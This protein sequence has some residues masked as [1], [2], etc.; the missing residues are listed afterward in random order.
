MKSTMVW[1][2]SLC[3]VLVAAV[4]LTFASAGTAAER[5]VLNVAGGYLG[6]GGPATNASFALASGVVRDANGNFYVSDALDC[7][8]R[9]VSASGL[10]TTFAGTGICGHSGD[11]GP[12][13]EARIAN[14]YSLAFDKHGN[15]LIGDIDVVRSITPGGII[16]TI[17]GNGRQG[18]SGDGGPATKA[19]FSAIYGM[20]VDSSGNIFIVDGNNNV[21]RQI[22]TNGIVRT[23]AGN[24]T[25]GFSGDGGPATS[26]SLNFPW[27]VAVD[28]GGHVYV[29]DDNNYRVRVFSV[30]GTISTFAGNGQAG[31]TGSGGPATDAAIGPNAGLHLAAGRLYIGG[32]TGLIWAVNMS[33]KTIDQIG[34]A[35]SSGYNGD[36]KPA[37]AT[38]F[39]Q[40][41]GLTVD[42]AGGLLVADSTENR[43]RHID[44][45]Q[46]VSTVA[47]GAIGD[48][49][50]GAGASFDFPGSVAHL[51]F[52]P[53]GNLYIADVGNCR[54]RKILPSGT[55]STVAGTGI[56]G[57]TGDGGLA[58]DA[59]LFSPAAVAA[60]GHGNLYIADTGNSVIRKIDPSGVITTYISSLSNGTY[61]IGA[62]VTG[63]AIDSSG[64]LIVSDSIWAI[65]KI[66]PSRDTSIIAG[67]L[68]GF[69]YN[70][71]NIPATQAWL[72]LPRE[73]A[74]DGS[75]NLYIADWLNNRVRKV[76]TNGIITTLAGNGVQGFGGDGGPASQAM[77]DLPSGVAADASGN[78][79]IADWINY[80]VRVVDSSGTIN[81]FAGSGRY[82]Y[83]GNDDLATNANMLPESVAVRGENLYVIDDSTYRIR[84]VH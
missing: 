81:T 21:V 15:L 57:Y 66:T 26:A 22:D 5:R 84:K 79:Y 41:D 31:N 63:M 36:G 27:G 60:D 29:S 59:T 47:G 1:S 19:T 46:I 9:R 61:S 82:G 14:V 56:C 45:N 58:V 83:N 25:R 28:A 70:G 78:V 7:R 39:G 53:S 44:S 11:G 76:D 32:L 6:D 55:I 10:I 54:I 23:V 73:I 68:F 3:G 52:D 2:T 69:G 77:L 67:T 62:Q 72:A 75:G 12:A 33:S 49:G 40:I 38:N 42:G 37:L 30:G 71:D 16:S 4:V 20:T 80:R 48:G 50:R 34:G 51:S 13:R 24:H 74:I 43:I 64:N 8:I 65:W 18:Y 35:T 17:A